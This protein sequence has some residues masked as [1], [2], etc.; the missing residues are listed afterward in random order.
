MLRI[1]GI[2]AA[3]LSATLFLAACESSEERAQKHYESGMS[4]LEQGDVARAEVEFRNVFKLNPRH[5]E[6]RLAYARTQSDAGKIRGAF[7]QYLT[8][9]EFYPENLEG[10]IELA[11]M[12]ML[13]R[14]WEEGERH[15]R[16]AYELAPDN[17]DVLA[18]IAALDFVKARRDSNEPEARK[19]A[20]I[21]KDVLETNPEDGIARRIV[22]EH[23]VNRQEFDQAL[24]QLN[25][26][27]EFEPDSF[28]LL[29][30]RLQVQYELGDNEGVEASLKEMVS[31]FPENIDLQRT[32]IAWYLER[33]DLEGAEAFLREL[34]NRPDAEPA[35]KIV[36]VQFLTETQGP[37][38][39]RAELARLVESEE[40]NLVYRALLASMDFEEGKQDEAIAELEQVLEQNEP[41][42]DRRNSQILLARMLIQTNNPVGA[43]SLVE[44]IL[45]ED[46]GHV[47]ALKMQAAWL[48]DEDKPSE[49][50]VALRTALAGAPNDASIMTLMGQAHERE[51]ARELAG[52]RYALAVDVSGAAPAESL[53]YAS[54][55]MADNRIESAQSVIQEA[56]N[57]APQNIE[58]LRNMAMIY[59]AQQDWNRATRI[60]WSLRALETDQ[61]TNVANGIE[62]E[63]LS[64]QER[65]E[66][67]IS[68]L[69]DMLSEDTGNTGALA[70]LVE[71]QVRDGQL[72]EATALLEEQLVARPNDPSLRFLRAGLYFLEDDRARAE[73]EYKKLLEEF[74]GNDRVLRTYYSLLIAEGRD[75]EAGELVDKVIAQRPDASSALLLKAERLEKAQDFEG[76]IAI[77]EDLYAKNSSSVI[78]ANNLASLITTHRTDPES[79]ERG[80]AIASRLKGTTFPPLQDTYGWIEYRRGNYEEALAYLEPAAAGLP[81][82]PLVQF[83]LGMTYAALERTQEARETLTRA[84]EI[85][86]DRP[87]PQFDVARET[88]EKLPAPE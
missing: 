43:R 22:V 9:V 87:L 5:K 86:G 61:A 75:A 2:T 8:L 35:A 63:V 65:T 12:A 80:F 36:V 73:E 79:L 33:N 71:T 14:D 70:A 16:A 44:E 85:A 76:A 81:E 39:A 34:A 60:V 64:R 51:G 82:D 58:L 46:S 37:E 57:K 49:A 69:K 56:V 48:I 66:D 55:L 1:P 24:V 59:I 29:M 6:A 68:F 21:L 20:E 88:L 13:N 15:G 18:L 74:P 84:L 67:T 10:R 23:L 11:R 31:K 52:E 42:D 3:L 4:L 77:Y 40:E 45:A 26:G 47:A 30:A 17:A 41:S 83:H 38:A 32:L 72:D 54:V 50:I 78:L 28:E 7:K 62:A 27:I 25:Q 19:Q 53:R